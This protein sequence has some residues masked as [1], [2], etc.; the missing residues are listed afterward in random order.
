MDCIWKSETYE[1]PLTFVAGLGYFTERDMV[2][3][4]EC[5]GYHQWFVGME[6]FLLLHG[7]ISQ[8]GLNE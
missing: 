7:T 4:M 6:V 2:A 1:K 3:G 5:H 8:C